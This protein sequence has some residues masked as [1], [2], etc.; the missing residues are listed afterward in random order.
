MGE[1]IRIDFGTQ[2]NAGRYGPDTGP[3]HINAR[4]EKVEE[5]Q[6]NFPIY[7]CE[8]LDEYETVSGGGGCRGLLS[9]GSE[10]LTLSGKV[11]AR[12]SIAGDTSIVAG[13]AGD[14]D[15]FMVRNGA[16]VP[17]AAIIAPGVRYIYS[18]G[19]LTSFSDSDLPPPVG[20]TFADQRLILPIADGRLFWTDIDDASSVDAL[21]FATAEGAPDGLVGAYAHKLQVWLPGKDST[22]VWQSTAN[23]DDPFQ[24]VPGGFIPHGSHSP[25]TM[26]ALGDVLFWVTDKNQVVAGSVGAVQVVSHNAISRDIESVPDKN[27]IVGFTYHSG[28]SGYYVLTCAA[29]TWQYCINTGKWFERTS[30]GRANWR[31]RHSA[32]FGDRWVIGDGAAATLYSVNKDTFSENGEPYLWT[33]RSA[34]MHAYPNR[35]CV[36]RLHLDFVTGVGV[37]SDDEHEAN[38]RVGMRYSDDGG[39]SWSPQL[40]RGLGRDGQH[41]VRVTFDGLGATGSQGRIWELEASAPVAR[42]LMY[43]AIEG[44][45]IGT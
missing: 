12:T 2:S 17:Q 34:P 3:R 1:P 16:D 8:G 29:W 35:I 9:M 43:A 37:N 25:H 28:G 6:P 45:V 13:I 14:G 18:A 23:A 4:I 40:T 7:A 39:R 32:K 30:N 26:K 31:G 11:L 19:T 21:S 20:V 41:R 15:V 36:D 44:D 38:P 24:R 27:S 10:L 5:G 42:G 33:L 22:E